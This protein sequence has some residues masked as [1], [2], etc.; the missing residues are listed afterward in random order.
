MHIA[1]TFQLSTDI[2]KHIDKQLT[3]IDKHI[4]NELSLA[5]VHY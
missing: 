3:Y 1:K 2:D 5:G 4:D